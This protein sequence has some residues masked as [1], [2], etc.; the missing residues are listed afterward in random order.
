MKFLLS[1]IAV[2]IGTIAILF[3]AFSVTHPP[4]LDGKYE[5]VG[6][7]LGFFIQ[8]GVALILV[9]YA[10]GVRIPRLRPESTGKKI[11]SGPSRNPSMWSKQFEGGV[12]YLEIQ[13]ENVLIVEDS[14][15]RIKQFKRWLP[16]ARIVASANRAIEAIRRDCPEIIFLDRDIVNS[17]GEEV[18]EFLAAQK[19]AGRVYVTSANPFGVE[20]IS[21]ILTDAGIKF[22]V[23]PFQMLGI[24]RVTKNQ[25][26]ENSTS[27]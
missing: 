4:I 25:T 7:G 20:V 11:H 8:S 10:L 12:R 9:A 13:D 22:E 15:A 17:L 21:K 14:L 24:V 6:F 3:A 23:I 16:L 5:V 26:V 2:I 19:F 27:K 18:A 1:W